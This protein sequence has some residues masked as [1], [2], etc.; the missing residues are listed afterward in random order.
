MQICVL[1][2]IGISVFAWVTEKTI[3]NPV[4]LFLLLWSLIFALSKKQLF[5]LTSV[6]YNT[7]LILMI[8]VVFV[9]AGYYLGKFFWNGN[10]YLQ[11]VATLRKEFSAHDIKY[12]SVF[13][14]CILVILISLPTVMTTM[15]YLLSGNSL[16]F[17]R[18]LAQASDSSLNTSQSGA[19][20]ALK[21][22]VVSPFIMILQPIV[23][24]DFYFG[25]RNRNLFILDIVIVG[26]RVLSDGSRSSLLY[27]IFSFVA[28]FVVKRLKYK[29]MGKQI[30]RAGKRKRNF[31][32]VAFV[33]TIGLVFLAWT[34][35][36]RSGENVLKDIYL[37]F[38]M[39]PLMFQQWKT[40][41]QGVHLGYGEASTNGFS[42]AVLYVLKNLKII[43]EYPLNWLDINTMIGNTQSQWL[44]ISSQGTRANAY[45]SLFWYFYVD[46]RLWGVIIGSL[47]Y[48][49]TVSMSLLQAIYKNSLRS[50][51]MYIFLLQGLIMSF[52]RFQFADM[53][54]AVAFVMIW[55]LFQQQETQNSD[56]LGD[57]KE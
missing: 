47:I 45:V 37:Y 29:R 36:S 40:I 44:V 31:I 11:R 9:L 32:I 27:L 30:H 35:L 6:D 33:V 26:L 10:Q 51:C 25:N 49:I 19:I 21:N 48:G 18:Q 39:E 15:Q 12:T 53:T 28:A 14:L 3:I 8:G 2:L 42:F 17:V 7:Y 57:I 23:A 46:G 13:I 34:T 54:Y 50:I 20:V 55:F 4:T 38:A 5:G 22:L 41:A 24:V 16:G 56:E 52:V 1:I 43:S